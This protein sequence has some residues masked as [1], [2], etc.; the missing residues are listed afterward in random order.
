[1]Q[2]I[3]WFDRKFDFSQSVSFP[4][5]LERLDGTP[6]RLRHKVK[7]VDLS[8]LTTKIADKWS[9]Q[10]H[11]GHLCDLETLWQG[12]LGD[13]LSGQTYLRSTDLENKQTDAANYNSQAI[14]DLLS[15]FEALR[16]NTVL[17]LTQLNEYDIHKS[18]LHPRLE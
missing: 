8:T 11:I 16:S 17:R 14:D 1:M 5:L 7:S 10:E 9:I 15:R 3:K 2:P 12:R 4:S 6:L 13:I 18:A